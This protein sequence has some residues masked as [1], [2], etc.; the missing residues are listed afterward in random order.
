MSNKRNL[1]IKQNTECFCPSSATPSYL[2]FEKLFNPSLNF[3][4][5]KNGHNF[6]D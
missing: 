3:L 6:K 1:K 4:I 5:C 2:T